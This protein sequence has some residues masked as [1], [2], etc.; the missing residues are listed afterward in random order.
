MSDKKI[1]FIGNLGGCT[2][3]YVKMLRESG[4]EAFL[5]IVFKKKDINGKPIFVHNQDPREQD[6]SLGKELP[7]WVRT[8]HLYSIKS[9][10][11]LRREFNQYDLNIAFKTMPAFLQFCK[12]PM[13][14]FGTGT[15]LREEVFRRGLRPFLL[16]RGVCLNIC[17]ML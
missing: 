16:R 7:L 11:G 8:F 3:W 5:Y 2:Y 4:V 15:N 13:L 10:L 12:P 9:I 1:A 6:K 14:S 17:L